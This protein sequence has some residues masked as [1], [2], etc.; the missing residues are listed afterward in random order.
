MQAFPDRSNDRATTIAGDWTWSANGPRIESMTS[1]ETTVRRAATAVRRPQGAG[2][3]LVRRDRAGRETW[4]GKWRVGDRQTMR[5]LGPRRGPGES[6][7]LTRREAEVTLRRLIGEE[8]GR[9]LQ[10]RLNLE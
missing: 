6:V 5:A 1:K 7:G 4:Y 2:S 9:P 10:E 3:L 8:T